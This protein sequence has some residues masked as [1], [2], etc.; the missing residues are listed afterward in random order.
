MAVRQ[1]RGVTDDDD[2]RNS[3]DCKSS[4]SQIAVEPRYQPRQDVMA[5]PPPRMPL[6]TTAMYSHTGRSI[7]SSATYFYETGLK[8]FQYRP[9]YYIRCKILRRHKRRN[10]RQRRA[11]NNSTDGVKKK[12]KKT[13]FIFTLNECERNDISNADFNARKAK[14][15]FKC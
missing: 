7:V 14:G 5:A 10:I 4:R 2:R 6:P 3:R 12:K 13:R 11:L 15:Y 8:V 1:P 9:A